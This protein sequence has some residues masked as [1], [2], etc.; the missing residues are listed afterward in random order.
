MQDMLLK[1]TH[2][3]NKINEKTKTPNKEKRN[4]YEHTRNKIAHN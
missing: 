4:R 1:H 2:D 3:Y